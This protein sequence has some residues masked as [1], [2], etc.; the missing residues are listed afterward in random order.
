MN[1]I[2]L[3]KSLKKEIQGHLTSKDIKLCN[4]IIE[5]G[6]TGKEREETVTNY[7]CYLNKSGYTFS[8]IEETANR[9]DIYLTMSQCL[10]FSYN[11]KFSD[12]LQIPRKYYA[13]APKNFESLLIAIPNSN[14]IVKAQT[15]NQNLGYSTRS[16]KTGNLICIKLYYNREKGKWSML[17]EASFID[18]HYPRFTVPCPSPCSAHVKTCIYKYESDIPIP[19]F[20]GECKL[21]PNRVNICELERELHELCGLASFYDYYALAMMCFDKWKNRPIRQN[22]NKSKSYNDLGV[23]T[24]FLETRPETKQQTDFKEVPLKES[25]RYESQMR[26]KGWIVKNRLSPCEHERRAHTRV[27]KSGKIV[28]VRG[29]IVNKGNTKAVYKIQN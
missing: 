13:P 4:N 20:T 11:L 15:F 26:A 19:L 5:S 29:S 6:I 2:S 25:A 27:L 1:S 23:S 12:S 18:T 3:I 14:L 8:D 21:S 9:M 16:D 7:L 17:Q 22:T 28:R 10:L 24:I